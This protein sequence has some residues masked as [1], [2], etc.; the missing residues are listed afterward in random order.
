MLLIIPLISFR[1]T[2]KF[3]EKLSNEN[4][5]AQYHLKNLTI[6]IKIMRLSYL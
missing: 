3:N 1:N 5:V 4:L 2:L 6:L